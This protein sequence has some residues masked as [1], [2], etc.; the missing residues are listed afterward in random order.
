MSDLIYS[1]GMLL[2]TLMLFARVIQSG[3]EATWNCRKYVTYRVSSD[4]CATLYNE[5]IQ[6]SSWVLR[7]P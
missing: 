6:N 7:S 4:F 5:Y 1:D 2:N 3:A